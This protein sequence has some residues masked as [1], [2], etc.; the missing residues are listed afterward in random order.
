MIY[1][2]LDQD[3]NIFFVEEFNK[4]N[5][6][7]YLRHTVRAGITGY[8]QMYGEYSTDYN[9]KLR[10]DLVYIKNYSLILDIQIL[11]QTM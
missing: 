10:F 4:Q 9:R 5:P 1:H 6:Y 8:A 11:S 3:Q 2:L 7:Y